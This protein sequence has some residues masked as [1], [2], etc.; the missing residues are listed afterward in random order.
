MGS[1]A[2]RV[3]AACVDVFVCTEIY[4]RQRTCVCVC[5]CVCVRACMHEHVRVWTHACVCSSFEYAFLHALAHVRTCILVSTWTNLCVCASLSMQVRTCAGA[6][7]HLSAK[8]Q[9]LQQVA[10]RIPFPPSFPKAWKPPS[11]AGARA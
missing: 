7:A 8:G 5:V 6:I 1:L 9:A 2:Q 11:G 4:V 3:A 10:C